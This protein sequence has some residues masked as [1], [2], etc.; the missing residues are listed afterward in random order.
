L[1]TQEGAVPEVDSSAIERIDYLAD[2]SQLLVTFVSR[3]RYLYFDVPPSIYRQF[4]NAESQGRYFNFH[5]RDRY[6]FRELA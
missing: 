3:R 1:S 5:I 4:L 6:D 2:K